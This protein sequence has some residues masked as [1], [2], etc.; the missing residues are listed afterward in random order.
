MLFRSSPFPSPPE[1]WCLSPSSLL[2]LCLFL[3]TF[4]SPAF[5]V[6]PSFSTSL[7]FPSVL[8][9][10]PL[11]LCPGLCPHSRA[12]DEHLPLDLGQW[13]PLSLELA[14]W[15]PERR[16]A[17][18][19]AAPPLLSCPSVLEAQSHTRTSLPLLRSISF[20]LPLWAHGSSC[21]Y[22]SIFRSLCAGSVPL[23]LSAFISGFQYPPRKALS[24]P[25]PD[26]CGPRSLT[27]E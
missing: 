14:R 25:H 24:I 6:S 2:S 3:T 1:P 21:P 17:S 15:N 8:L 4:L 16:S 9:C 18:P 22:T 12:Q 27:A 10:P 13:G 26:C 7:F 11:S 5:F 23:C 20:G 19:S